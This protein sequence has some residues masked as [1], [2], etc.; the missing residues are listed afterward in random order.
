MGT[1][2]AAD[3]STDLASDSVDDVAVDAVQEEISDS[4]TVDETSESTIPD[5][6][7]IEE[8]NDDTKT[9]ETNEEYTILDS[10]QTRRTG[11]DVANW[12]DLLIISSDTTDDY[13][14]TLINPL[15]IGGSIEFKNSV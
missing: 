1:A 10:E 15:T 11:I 4:S 5:Y 6:T 2:C 12:D 14:I 9:G 3:V 7:N 13:D 8:I